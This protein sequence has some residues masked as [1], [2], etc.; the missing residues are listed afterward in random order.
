MKT[1]GHPSEVGFKDIV[2]Q[3]RAENFDPER[4]I[5]LYKSCG[6]KYFVSMGVHHDNFDLWNS[7]HHTWNAA[8]MGPQRDIVGAWAK[9]ARDAGLR[10]GVTEHLERTYSWFNTNKG[11]DSAG[12]YAGVPYDGNDPAYV[13]FYIEPH[14]D[15]VRHYPKNPSDAWMQ[16][17]QQRIMDLIDQYDPDLLYTDG[18]VPFGTIGLAMVAHYYN[19]SVERRGALEAVYAL[20]NPG[21][22]SGDHAG[23]HGEFREGFATL[24]IE[25]GVVDGIHPEPWQTDTCLGGWF[26]DS[27]RQYKTPEKVIQMLVDIVS[28]NGNLLLNVGPAAD[29]TIPEMQQKPL[30]ALGEWLGA[31]GDAIYGTRP[32]KRAEGELKDGT[33]VRFTAKGDKV[34]AIV[35]TV[36]EN[37]E[38]YLEG[39]HLKGIKEARMPGAK[40][41]PRLSD[42]G[43]LIALPADTAPGET[44]ALELLTRR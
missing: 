6:A 41:P 44:I 38:I 25:R 23:H 29:G 21:R 8:K 28:K 40:Q 32:W 7:T 5:D 12:S 27:R 14:D 34:W 11:A 30:L 13:D 26:Y 18:G 22:H 35:K 42:D 37:R 10:F 43:T 16:H 1:Y 39:L 31:Y 4:L 36:P 24:D 2:K 3:W 17:W 33:P 20:K 9:A 19:R 15:T